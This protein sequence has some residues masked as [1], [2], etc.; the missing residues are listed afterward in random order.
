MFETS[1]LGAFG[2]ELTPH[3]EHWHSAAGADELVR[4]QLYAHDG[5]LLL[6]GVHQI[7]EQP[8]LLVA[9][10]RWFGSEVEDYRQTLTAA[11]AV[12]PTTPEIFIVSNAH[13]VN[14][15]PPERPDP[16]WDRNGNFPAQF[17]QRR[18]WHTDQSYRRPPPDISLFYA[19]KPAPRGQGQTLYANGLAAYDALPER[20]R[21]AVNDLQGLHVRPG[22]GRS[23]TA[24]RAGETPPALGPHEQPQPQPVARIHPV[25]GRRAL[26]LCEAGQMDWITG[27]FAGLEPGPDGEG[28]KLLYELMTHLTDARFTY[29]HEWEAGDLII[30]DNRSLVHAATWFDAA[31]HARV[32]WR[33]TVWGTPGAFYAGEARSW[34]PRR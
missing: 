7:A 4:E 1:P 13:P 29:T 6:R 12:H 10:S 16:P 24:V 11:S 34:V 28:A 14:R 27:P 3:S 17:P 31:H 8:E 19:V 30:Y 23:E 26:Y 22:S 33:P 25:T 9:L 32:M 15:Q 18:G 5:L 20:L 2:A 21:V